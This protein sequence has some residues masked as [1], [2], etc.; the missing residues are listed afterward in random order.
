MAASIFAISA[1]SASTVRLSQ[2]TIAD[3]MR[4]AHRRRY[5]ANNAAAGRKKCLLLAQ[6]GHW[7]PAERCLLS[8]VKRTVGC[9]T[10]S[11][12]SGQ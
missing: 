5:L 7:H 6:S 9:L 1:R 8:G 12:P 4:E 11:G 2:T 3:E 10:R